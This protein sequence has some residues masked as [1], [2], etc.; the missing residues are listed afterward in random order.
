MESKTN[1][2]KKQGIKGGFDKA[3]IAISLAIALMLVLSITVITAIAADSGNE[4]YF[5]SEASDNGNGTQAKP[6]NS[7]KS[8]EGL[9]LTPGS[10]IY[11][12][13]GSQFRE[14]LR[15]VG[16]NGSES[17]PIIVTSYGGGNLIPRIDGCDTVGEGVLY[18]ENCSWITISDLEICDTATYEADRRGVLVIGNSDEDDVECYSGITLDGLYV[19]DIVGITDDALCGGIQIWSSGNAR[20]DGITVSNCYITDVSGVGIGINRVSENGLAPVSPCLAEFASY[21]NTNVDI[22]YNI[23]KRTG[24]SAV[25]VSNLLGGVI[26][27]NTSDE[28]S[29]GCDFGNSFVASYVDGTVVQYNE[30]YLNLASGRGG[31]MLCVGDYCRNTVWQYNYSHDNA[32][33]LFTHCGS[34]DDQAYDGRTVLRYNLS[35]NDRGSD[36]IISADCGLGELEIYNN[37]VYC[38]SGSAPAIANISGGKVS[39]YN[40]LIYSSV[41]SSLSIE[42]EVKNGGLISN[43]LVYSTDGVTVSGIEAFR[44]LNSNGCYQDPLF[45]GKIGACVAA[46]TGMSAAAALQVKNGSPALTAGRQT[47]EA[48]ADFFGNSNVASVG[49]FCGEGRESVQYDYPLDADGLRDYQYN[50]VKIIRN[51]PYTTVTTYKGGTKTLCLDIYMAEDCTDL[52]R[53]LMLMIHGGGFTTG[54]A[55]EQ[56]YAVKISK[57]MAQKG[58]IVASIDY[59]TRESSDMSVEGGKAA[60]LDDATADANAALEWLRARSGEYGFNPDYI[61]IAGGSAGGATAVCYA[62]AEDSR[63]FD[64]SGIVA[65][66]N[67]WGGPR[68]IFDEHYD[69]DFSQDDNFP[70]IFIHGTGDTTMEYTHSLTTYE[71]MV[72]KGIIASWNPIAG[73]EHSLLGT[74]DTYEMTVGLVS[75]FFADR[76][77]EKIAAEGGYTQPSERVSGE[78]TQSDQ[79]PESTRDIIYPNADTFLYSNSAGKYA[80][81][82]NEKNLSVYDTSNSSYKRTSVLRFDTLPDTDGSYLNK[83]VLHFRVTDTSGISAG[84]PQMLDIY[85][86]KDNYWF[87]DELTWVNTPDYTD[88]VYLGTVEVTGTGNYSLDISNY[89]YDVRAEGGRTVTVLLQANEAPSSAKRTEIASYE[90]G[91]N[92]PY[93]E[94]SYSDTPVSVHKLTVKLNGPGTADLYE[95]RA[96]SG[97][98]VIINVTPAAGYV[99]SD[100]TLGTA[101]MGVLAQINGN[102]ITVSRISADTVVNIYFGIDDSVVVASDSTTVQYGSATTPVVNTTDSSDPTNVNPLFLC[103]KGA[104]S[105]GNNNTNRIIWLKFDISD[106]DFSNENIFFEI[107]CYKNVEFSGKTMP[108]DVYATTFSDWTSEGFAWND[109]PFADGLQYGS[110]EY[111][112]GYGATKVGR[113]TVNGA[114]KW[115]TVDVTEYVRA[116][117]VSGF[118]SFSLMLVDSDFKNTSPIARFV[119]THGTTSLDGVSLAPRLTTESASSGDNSERIDLDVDLLGESNGSVSGY[120]DVVKGGAAILEITPAD[121]YT[122]RL[123]IDG[124]E[125]KIYDGK[126]CIFGADESTEIS[127]VFLKNYSLTVE[128]DEKSSADINIA[129]VARGDE[130]TIRFATEAGYKPIVKI[131]GHLQTLVGNSV[132]ITVIQDISIT[133]EAIDISE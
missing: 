57:L 130:I 21:A 64:K 96:I 76:L 1:G 3:W 123:T 69:S 8:I 60:A 47:T 10:K 11:I 74:D 27:H 24:Q 44:E 90:S 37:T 121:G 15:L 129:T 100:V 29:V 4:Y 58:Y 14:Q 43:N 85:A 93:L 48:V 35:V 95:A 16:V 116:L 84:S 92:A 7:L 65:V 131:N 128:C 118:T 80:N 9:D 75:E 19:H 105:G 126:A 125:R 98:S 110:S 91:R 53:P 34:L 20:F 39:F 87:V 59:R 122:A 45:S 41:N 30:G 119:S 99:A 18:I 46:R 49:F 73:A 132:T 61:F 124:T 82:S 26:E 70:T 28:G 55:K 12:K 40:N 108:V 133:V 38:G 51:I 17:S 25:S 50:D 83:T 33:G 117:R 113:F 36:A 79:L 109:Q 56:S 31:A 103:T 78:T 5:D 112:V 114:S 89:V 104:S 81:Y 111:E 52:N 6:F 106:C 63:G 127:V 97:S 42:D 77:A 67:L 88:K 54:S 101:A 120:T 115:Y 107:Y 66:A 22:S 72:E 71:K 23:I 2:K 32:S 102:Q 13:R 86:L 94:C 62:F 68:D